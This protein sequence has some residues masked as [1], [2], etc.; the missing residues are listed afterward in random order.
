[1]KDEMENNFYHFSFLI[2]YPG[3]KYHQLDGI[4][5]PNRSLDLFVSIMHNIIHVLG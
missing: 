3:I 5:N 4:L 2:A 1:V